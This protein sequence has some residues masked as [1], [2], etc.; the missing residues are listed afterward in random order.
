MGPPSL[1]KTKGKNRNNNDV[2]IN[3]GGSFLKKQTMMITI[4]RI[5]LILTYDKNQND[6]NF[7]CDNHEVAWGFA[8]QVRRGVVSSVPL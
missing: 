3:N 8:S 2:N 7:L 4:I 5:I 6:D 1:C